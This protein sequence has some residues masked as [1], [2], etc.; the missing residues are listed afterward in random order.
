MALGIN[1]LN[2]GRPLN[3]CGLMAAKGLQGVRVSANYDQKPWAP[4]PDH[5]L[6]SLVQEPRAHGMLPYVV[7]R[8]AET[9]WRLPADAQPYVGAGNES[10]LFDLFGWPTRKGYVQKARAIIEACEQRGFPCG[11]AVIHNLNDDGLDY[12][13]AVMRELQPPAWVD[14]DF[15]WYWH[16]THR[17][18]KPSW[19]AKNEDGDTLKRQFERLREI[20]G[21]DRGLVCSELNGFSASHGMTEL[22][23]AEWYAFW[24]ELSP[25]MGIKHLFAYHLNDGDTS[26]RADADHGFQ[27]DWV[28]KLR[29][30]A[31]LGQGQWATGVTQ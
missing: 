21:P 29:A 20:A 30:D 2:E 28:W 14:F 3:V 12:G 26:V 7:V 9:V 13:E 27:K 4:I 5:D 8:D 11:A 6:K 17:N 10:S 1:A 24:R 25:H 22:D 31:F 15:H 19:D 18:I 16:P 23:I